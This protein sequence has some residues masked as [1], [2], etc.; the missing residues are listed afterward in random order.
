MIDA[1]VCEEA[2][3]NYIYFRFMGGVTDMTKRSRRVQ[4]LAEVLGKNDFR[5]EVRGDLVVARVK[6]LSIEGM[7][8]RLNLVGVLVAFS[9]QLDVQMV[10]DRQI[11]LQ[12][13]HF[14]QLIISTLNLSKQG[15]T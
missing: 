13:D 15:V 14:N 7:E 11:S 2:N 9:R 6:K 8:Q 1:Y 4:F 12:A 10:N 3:S 5:V